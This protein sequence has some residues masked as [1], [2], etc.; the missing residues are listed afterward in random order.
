VRYTDAKRGRLNARNK[1]GASVMQR[2]ARDTGGADFD[3]RE[4]DMAVHFKA[5]GEQ[6][7]SSYEMAYHSANPAGDGTFRKLSI[8]V[9]RPG[10]TVHAKSGYYAR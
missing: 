10:L 9:K 2:L 7:R 1:Y 3:A 8:R 5:I 6:L 4:G